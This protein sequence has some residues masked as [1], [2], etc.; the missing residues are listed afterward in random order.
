MSLLYNS[1]KMTLEHLV[2]VVKVADEEVLRQYTK[3]SKNLNLDEGRK[4]YFVGMGLFFINLVSYASV[5]RELFGPM[6]FHARIILNVPD[7]GYNIRGVLGMINDEN[8]SE[9]R[10]INPTIEFYKKFNSVVRFPTFIAGVGLVGKIG[11]DLLNY[12]SSGEPINQDSYNYLIYGIGLLSLASSMYIKDID[13]KLLNKKPF[14][15][16][17]SSWMKDKISSLVPEPSPEPSPEPTPVPIQPYS[18]LEEYVQPNL[19]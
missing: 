8:T 2:K 17:A 3:L 4:K 12:T 5:G 14:W 16:S 19:K 6:E 18:R 13:P 9:E 15:K 7:C 11:V 10:V 1:D